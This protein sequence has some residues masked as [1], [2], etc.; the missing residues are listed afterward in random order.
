MQVSRGFRA[1]IKCKCIPISLLAQSFLYSLIILCFLHQKPH[2]GKGRPAG[3][4]KS[5]PM[6][7]N[8]Q[9]WPQLPLLIGELLRDR[10]SRPDAPNCCPAQPF[11]RLLS[12]HRHFALLSGLVQ[13]SQILFCLYAGN[14]QKCACS[15]RSIV[16][17]PGWDCSFRHTHFGMCWCR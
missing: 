9:F 8:N 13:S 11:G 4:C 5:S 14:G 10:S 16:Q 17:M 2:R 12:G 1:L 6:A 15:V 3:S 7:S